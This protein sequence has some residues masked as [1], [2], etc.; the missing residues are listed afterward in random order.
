[1]GD[2]LDTVTYVTLSWKGEAVL[3]LMQDLY[4]RAC[5]DKYKRFGDPKS[6]P[7]K[8]VVSGKKA[9]CYLEINSG[10]LFPI[11]SAI[12]GTWKEVR[13]RY[14]FSTKVQEGQGR[15]REEDVSN[16]PKED[17]EQTDDRSYNSYEVL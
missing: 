14:C 1:M 2:M 4:K 12:N 3:D 11:E 8:I 16:N 13:V 5:H 10:D 15:R 9:Q 17:E 7:F 6:G